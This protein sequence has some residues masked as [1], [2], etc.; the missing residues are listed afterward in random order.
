[1]P[2]KVIT[3]KVRFSYANVFEPKSV[4]GGTPKYS[5][6]LIIPKSDKKT[7]DKINTAIETVKKEGVHKWG[8][9]IPAN[10]KLPLRDG[11]KDRPD[12]EAY[13]NSYFINVNCTRLLYA[14]MINKL[15]AYISPSNSDSLISIHR[16][17]RNKGPICSGGKT[18]P[19]RGREVKNKKSQ[20]QNKSF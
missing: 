13:A 18:V 2:T 9:K 1:M 6:S 10:L 3:G 7:L 5:V 8:G 4:N 17:N 19:F 16:Y 12:D 15:Y 14:Y 11:D 20:F